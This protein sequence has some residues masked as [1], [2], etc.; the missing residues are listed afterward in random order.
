MVSAALV[1]DAFHSLAELFGLLG[2][3]AVIMSEGFLYARTNGFT[4]RYGDETTPTTAST[5]APVPAD[6]GAGFG[7]TSTVGWD[8]GKLW[9]RN[10]TA[11]SNATIVLNPVALKPRIYGVTEWRS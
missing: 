10:T 7:P 1:D 6:G 5:G 2:G 11:G 3:N 8:L 4:W 9:V